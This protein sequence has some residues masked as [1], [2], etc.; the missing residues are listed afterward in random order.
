MLSGMGMLCLW[1][2][3]GSVPAGHVMGWRRVT[4]GPLTAVRVSVRGGGCMSAV[5]WVGGWPLHV[6]PGIPTLLPA[7]PPTGYLHLSPPLH[8]LHW[9]TVWRPC[10]HPSN[11][12]LRRQGSRVHR[13]FCH[14]KQTQ[15]SSI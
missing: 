15:T 8:L 13:M 10:G 1:M 9:G 4:P 2:L 11:H 14:N 6:H 7:A 12:G 3:P 5:G